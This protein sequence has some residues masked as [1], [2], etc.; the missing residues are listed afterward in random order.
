MIFSPVG[1]VVAAAD[2]GI[3]VAAFDILFPVLLLG[4]RS[5]RFPAEGAE[6]ALL[7]F[8]V[9]WFVGTFVGSLVGSLLSESPV[10]VLPTDD[11]AAVA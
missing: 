4:L 3:S 6:V 5:S 8:I 10:P 7:V 11:G 2:S 1:A 9:G